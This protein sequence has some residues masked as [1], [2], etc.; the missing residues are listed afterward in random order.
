MSSKFHVIDIAGTQIECVASD[1]NSE[2][3][4]QCNLEKTAIINEWIQIHR[5]FCLACGENPPCYQC[6]KRQCEDWCNTQQHIDEYGTRRGCLRMALGK[7]CE[8]FNCER[9][10]KGWWE[11]DWKAHFN[12]IKGSAS[13]KILEVMK[14]RDKKKKKMKRK[15]MKSKAKEN[16]SVGKTKKKSKKTKAKK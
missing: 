9:G 2:D 14:K 15:K 3:C 8:N 1:K 4:P 5:Q 7:W 12:L 16:V 10:F 13:E 11:Q 6:L